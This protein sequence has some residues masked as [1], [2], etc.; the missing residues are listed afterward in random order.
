[1]HRLQSTIYIHPLGL[2]H[3]TVQRFASG[4]D[5]SNY[6]GRVLYM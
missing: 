2:L 4:L 5:V 1:M 3:R 6:S